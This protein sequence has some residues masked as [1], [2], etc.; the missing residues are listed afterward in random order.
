MHDELFIKI[1][2][3]AK[4][5]KKVKKLINVCAWCPKNTYPPL[6]EF[7]EYSHGLCERHYQLLSKHAV[8]ELK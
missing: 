3:K 2:D 6:N 5:K 4:K 8:K 7:E 1:T